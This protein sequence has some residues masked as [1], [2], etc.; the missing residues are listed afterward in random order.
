MFN[1]NICFKFLIFCIILYIFYN[2]SFCF[3]NKGGNIKNILNIEHI[4]KTE[5]PLKI[6]ELNNINSQCNISMFENMIEMK[7]QKK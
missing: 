6:S 3:T 4:S 1:L 5:L 7:D 2:F